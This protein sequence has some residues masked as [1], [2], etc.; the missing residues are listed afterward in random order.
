[1]TR[2]ADEEKDSIHR[3]GLSDFSG[4]FLDMTMPNLIQTAM[5]FGAHTIWDG[6]RRPRARVK[7]DIPF[8]IE[9]ISTD[10][11]TAVL[12]SNSLET[13][14]VAFEF[15]PQSSGTTVRR[16]IDLRYSTENGNADLPTSVF[17]KSSPRF[18]NRLTLGLTKTIENE[19]MFYRKIRPLLPLEAP[20]GYHSAYDLESGR[21][22][23][24]LEDL[25]RTK[26]ANFCSPSSIIDHSKAEDMVRVL[27]ALHG[28]FYGQPQ[29][30]DTFPWLQSF[31][32]WWRT[33]YE[34][35]GLRRFH[36]AAIE[37]AASVIPN[38]VYSRRAEI[39]PAQ[40][41]SLS[42][43]LGHPKT[44][45]HGD[46]H[47]GNWYI[48]RDGRMGLCDWQCVSIGNWARDFAYA[49]SATLSIE[50]RRAWEHDLLDLYLQQIESATGCKIAFDDAW[51]LYRQQAIAAL[52]MW[53]PTLCHSP[54]MPD[55]QPE[56][57]SVEMIKR[58]TTAM[59][60]LESLAAV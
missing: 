56:A 22:I 35:F 15:G 47:L 23:H 27:A 33:G 46:V 26:G 9:A 50:D 8:A 32:D 43:H 40:I 1:M 19:A 25:V 42:T 39:W 13:K 20:R 14:V 4:A 5:R 24:L 41:R 53:T 28:T 31:P 44:L 16:R 48:T 37:K 6:V 29:L 58:I 7:S 60:D 59:S 49:V 30:E 54:L 2:C 11:L 38:D 52:L 10:W 36:D 34:G 12:C 51:T 57:V 18:V 3:G 21:S 45:I 55:M 17:A